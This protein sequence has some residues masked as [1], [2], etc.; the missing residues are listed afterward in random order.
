MWDHTHGPEKGHSCN[1][2]AAALPLGEPPCSGHVTTMKIAGLTWLLSQ[3]LCERSQSLLALGSSLL[4]VVSWIMLAAV[5]WTHLESAGTSSLP[6]LL[7]QPVA[8][9]STECL[10][11]RMPISYTLLVR[12][13][14]PNGDGRCYAPHWLARWQVARRLA[15][16][17]KLLRERFPHTLWF[18]INFYI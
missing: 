6:L 7:V 1:G 17:V 13:V 15:L 11:L 12:R 16:R 2:C 8:V 18:L 4:S 10:A 3:V 9:E 5:T 14:L